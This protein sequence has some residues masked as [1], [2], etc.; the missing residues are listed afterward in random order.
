MLCRESAG[1]RPAAFRDKEP[2]SGASQGILF[3]LAWQ[4]IAVQ[5]ACQS[6]HAPAHR[7]PGSPHGPATNVHWT[8]AKGLS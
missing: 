1:I 2:E 6:P 3:L 4:L 5:K 8:L 7:C